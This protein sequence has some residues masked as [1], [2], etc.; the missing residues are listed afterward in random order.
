MVIFGPVPAIAP[1]F[2]VQFPEGNP[3]NNTLPVAIEQVGCVVVPIAG[4]EGVAGC[5][6]MITFADAKEVH[7]AA[8]VT[9]YVYVPANIP[10]IVVLA[11]FPVIEPGFTVQFPAG[12]PFKTILPVETEHPGCVIVPNAGAEGVTGCARITTFADTGEVHP[13]ALVTV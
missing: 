5:A 1:G 2:M 3:L 13:A 8:L 7:P 12:K 9:V 10:D 4:A 11:V 6:L